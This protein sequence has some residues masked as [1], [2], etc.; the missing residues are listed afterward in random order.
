MSQAGRQRAGGRTEDELPPHL[1]TEMEA[2]VVH[3]CLHVGWNFELW[4][5]DFTPM[6]YG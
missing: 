3:R 1:A 6:L 5:Y 4:E 2:G